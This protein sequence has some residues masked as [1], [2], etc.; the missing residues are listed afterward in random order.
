[1]NKNITR[2][3]RERIES[4]KKKRAAD[5][6]EIQGKLAEARS[7]VDS[8]EQ[9]I[10]LATAQMN[11]DAFEKA[12]A[13]K[14]KAQTAVDM[15]SARY[16]QLVKKEFISEAE[17]DSVIDSLLAY[18][19]QLADDFKKKLAPM[20]RELVALHRNYLEAVRD[21]EQTMNQWQ[22]EIHANYNT[23]GRQTWVDEITG[24]RTVRAKTPVPVRIIPYNGCDEATQLGSYLNRASSLTDGGSM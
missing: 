16:S 11:L 22:Y 2:E 1:M 18:E 5:L 4:L 3:V 9:T 21:T 15:Y 17:S 23:R 6:A 12:T 24:E 20:L 19:D 14:Q 8:A 10:Q 7:K 13:A